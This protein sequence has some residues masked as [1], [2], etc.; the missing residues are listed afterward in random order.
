M[1]AVGLRAPG[2]FF[3]FTTSSSGDSSLTNPEFML[4]CLCLA[5]SPFIKIQLFNMDKYGID[6]QKIVYHPARIAEWLEASDDWE[7]AKKVYPIYIELSPSGACNHRCIFCAVDYIGYKP[8]FLDTAKLKQVLTEM[9]AKGVKSVM[10]G[11]EGEPLLHPQIIDL[12]NHAKKSGL[13][14]SYTTNGVLLS[15]KFIKEALQSVTWIKVSLNAGSPESY[16]KIHRTK[17]EDFNKVIDNLRRAVNF[18]KENNIN[19]TLG[20]QMVLLPENAH[21]A[22][23]LAKL[24]KEIGLDYFVVKPYSQHKF[25][26]TKQYE[27]IKYESYLKLGE[28]L[29]EISND[30]FNAVFRGHTMKKWDQQ[31]RPY[32]TCY[33]TPFFWG[34]LMAN[35]DLYSC[36]AFL[37]DDRFN[38]GN[39]NIESFSE[40]WEGEKRKKNWELL[41]NNFNI[42]EC[43]NNCRMDEVNRYLSQL[44]DQPPEHVNF[45]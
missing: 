28:E 31:E 44:K 13:D 9:G 18:K 38:C 12:T 36:S 39:I 29:K 25:S 35:G 8:I 34:Y 24:L 42:S 15:D 22:L 2:G 20:A 19:C 14:V 32:Q 40:I 43:R 1:T 11:G 3:Q 41:K 4:K 7:K 6:S 5:V 33:S 30:S 17:G 26:L 45:I 21:E 23:S 10:M 37:N 16:H 27:E